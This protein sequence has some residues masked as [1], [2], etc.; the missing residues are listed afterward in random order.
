MLE[1]LSRVYEGLYE[2]K[3]VKKLKNQ[4]K[5]VEDGLGQIDYYNWL[6]ESL[7]HRQIPLEYK[8]Y[9]VKRKEQESSKLGKLLDKKG[10]T[11]GTRIKKIKGQLEHTRWMDPDEE[12]LDLDK[13]YEDSIDKINDFVSE[14]GYKF[15]NVEEDVHELRRRLRWLSIYP[16]A[17]GGT[18]RYA[19][20]ILDKPEFLKKYLTESIVNSP[21]NK[22]PES[23]EKSAF[24]LINKNYFLALSWL[25]DRLGSLKDEGLLQAGLSE[26]ISA[27]SGKAIDE[28]IAIAQSLLG[29]KQRPVRVILDEAENITRT[30]FEEKIH[31]YLLFGTMTLASVP[32]SEP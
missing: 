13:F 9:I 27:V 29:K 28:S 2:G 31:E 8:E 1:G 18:I 25:I 6:S 32:H 16:Q 24:L 19:P 5:V 23:H 30:F 4:F 22:L 21:Y 14:T 15:D 3:K 7:K 20:E 10:W 11:D 12:V 26:A 17:L